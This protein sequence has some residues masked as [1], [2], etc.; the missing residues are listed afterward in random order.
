MAFILR[1]DEVS[2]HRSVETTHHGVT[3]HWMKPDASFSSLMSQ[4]VLTWALTV[5]DDR[6][7]MLQAEKPCRPSPG[8]SRCTRGSSQW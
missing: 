3:S 4:A 6:Q 7:C 8:K 1:G 5:S 2:M